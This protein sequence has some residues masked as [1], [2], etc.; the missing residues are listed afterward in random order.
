MHT[1]RQRSFVMRI[2]STLA[3]PPAHV[4]RGWKSNT[5]NELP[6]CI[7]VMNSMNADRQRIFQA[8]TVPEYIE[9]W[10]S[11]PG[12][13]DGTTVFASEDSLSITYRGAENERSRIFCQYRAV[14]RSKLLFTWRNVSTSDGPASLVKVRLL[15]DFGR[16]TVHVTHVGLSSLEREWHQDL[17]TASLQRLRNLF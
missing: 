3:Q 5:S 14:R 2:N 7:S 17:W 15:G 13:L 6:F 4:I 9:T 16:T 12:A 8:V 1:S 10:L 11:P